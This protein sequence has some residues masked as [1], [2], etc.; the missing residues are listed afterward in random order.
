MLP[1]LPLP[2]LSKKPGLACGM[3]VVAVPFLG[4]PGWA[5]VVGRAACRE[6][7]YSSLELHTGIEG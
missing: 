4:R 3:P 2:L 7:F 5:V 6:A 1:P